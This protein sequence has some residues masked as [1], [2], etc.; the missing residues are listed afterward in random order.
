MTAREA[1][2]L[3]LKR[4]DDGNKY[5]NLE[6]DA[7]LKKHNFSSADRGLFTTI[8]YG[9]IERRITIDYI[10]GRFSKQTVEEL[11]SD[12]L[13]ALRVG[14]Y[15]IMYLDRVPDSAAC[16]E[17]VEI[18]KRYCKSKGA[19][20]Y[21]NAVLRNIIR[22]KDSI[23]YPDKKK[24]LIKYLSVTYSCPEWL[25]EKWKGDYGTRRAESIL[26]TLNDI[27]PLTFRVN[28]LKK[29]REQILSELLEAGYTAY[30]TRCK[31]GIRFEKNVPLSELNW[32]KNGEM[33]VQDE[34]SQYCAAML[35]AQSGER[36]IDTCACPGGKS[37][38]IAIDMENKGSVLSLDLHENKLSL[39]RRGAKSLGIDI[40]ETGVQNGTKFREDLIESADRVLCDVPCSGLGVIAKKPEIRYKDPDD[41]A[42]LPRVQYAILSNG[43][44]YVKK[45]GVLVYSTCTL[46]VLENERVAERFLAEHPEFKLEGMQ[47]FFPDTDGTDGFFTA[48]FIKHRK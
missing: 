18:V 22:N 21:A 14:V 10:I 45:G 19:P 40:I 37:F 25:C 33:F 36:V 12:M 39:V 41:I 30:P 29:S 34:A 2:F 23:V 44:Q 31:S 6:I 16:N 3:S 11:E 48:K 24:E 8:V 1:A 7:A 26:A 27:P 35:E 42:R 15:Q 47:T 13:C 32:V 46:N 38:S 17:T 28:T 43:A 5:S 9:V 20:P 4:C